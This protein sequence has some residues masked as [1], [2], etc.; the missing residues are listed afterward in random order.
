LALTIR[1]VVGRRHARRFWWTLIAVG[2]MA[3]LGPCDA[4]SAQTRPVSGADVAAFA[5][6]FLELQQVDGGFDVPPKVQAH[7]KSEIALAL[8]ADAAREPGYAEAAM[9]DHAWVIAH[10]LEPGGGVN[11]EGPLSPY[12]FEC[13]QHWFLIAS[14]LLSALTDTLPGTRERQ[15]AVWGFLQATNPARQDFYLDNEVNYGPFFAYR[16]VDRDGHF[17]TQFPFKGA[18]EIGAALWSLSLARAAGQIGTGSPDPDSLLM[19]EYLER[20]VRQVEQTPQLL[21]FYDPGEGRWIRSILWHNPGWWD[22]E[23]PDWKYA[24]HLEEGAL[25]Y[26]RLT[27]LEDL[28]GEIHAFLQQ[29]LARIQSDGTIAEFPD[30]YG[31]PAYEY[32]EALSVLGL[33]AITFANSDRWLAAQCLEGGQRIIEFVRAAFVPQS[34]EDNALLLAGLARLLK[35]GDALAAFAMD[36]RE[37]PE[38]GLTDGGRLTLQIVPSVVTGP[39]SVRWSLP[40][41]AAGVLRVFDVT[42]R[43]LKTVTLTEP[44]LAGSVAWDARGDDGHGLPGGRYYMILDTPL[45]RQAQAFVLER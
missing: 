37:G 19:A 40:S 7:L 14:R 24:L 28:D 9:R 30:G 34:S 33:A 22:V 3:G 20:S 43:Q 36:V 44:A 26:E 8:A 18:Y 39:V 45:G 25:E 29:L 2:A 15:R 12:F 11:W 4:P 35:A 32:G 16:S 21:G 23:E 10:H 38:P 42:G 5:A 41:A 31:T 6:P 17:M 1:T 27:G 13:H